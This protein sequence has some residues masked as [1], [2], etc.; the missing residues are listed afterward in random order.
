MPERAR[1]IV[2]A[3]MGNE[4]D[5]EQQMLHMLMC[6]NEFE[7]EGLIAVTGKYLR[8][9]DKDP[10]RQKLHPELF[11]KLIDGYAKVYPNLK[12]HAARLAHA[13]TLAWRR[14][15]RPD[16]LRHRGCGRGESERGIE[17]DHCCGHQARS[18]TSANRCQRRGEHAGPGAPATIAPPIRR[19]S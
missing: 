4:P 12:L 7:V 11:T 19:R 16:G 13:G 18:E 2:L 1:L 8:P 10:Y 5:E 15:Q 6:A 9:E 14:R 3:D 17:T